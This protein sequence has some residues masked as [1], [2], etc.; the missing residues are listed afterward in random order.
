M[1][2]KTKKQRTI[3]YAFK[4]LIDGVVDK[5]IEVVLKLNNRKGGY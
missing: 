4:L 3:M 2:M 1:N 5:G